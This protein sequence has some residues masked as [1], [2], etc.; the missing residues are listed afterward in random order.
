MTYDPYPG[1]SH[2]VSQKWDSYLY[3]NFRIYLVPSSPW[4]SPLR[5]ATYWNFVLLQAMF[6][7][8]ISVSY[9]PQGET[10][11][12]KFCK[13]DTYP[14][15]STRWIPLCHNYSCG[16]PILPTRSWSL[17][18]VHFPSKTRFRL[19]GGCYPVHCFSLLSFLPSVFARWSRSRCSLW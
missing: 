10:L 6:A 17:L 12:L 3:S 7:K 9:A 14:L 1:S 2:Y 8:Q 15:C 16:L 13:T 5:G 18:E 4:S 19:R 11:S